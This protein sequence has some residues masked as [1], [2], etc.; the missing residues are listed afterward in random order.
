MSKRGIAHSQ[1][2]LEHLR[3][4]AQFCA[5]L[6]SSAQF[7][8]AVLCSAQF[9]LLETAD[10]CS[11]MDVVFQGVQT[12]RNTTLQLQHQNFIVT[13]NLWEY[14]DAKILT[15]YPTSTFES[16]FPPRLSLAESLFRNRFCLRS[17][18]RPAAS[19]PSLAG[20]RASRA[21]RGVAIDGRG[22][23]A[24]LGSSMSLR[25]ASLWLTAVCRLLWQ[26]SLMA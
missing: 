11:N 12:P 26:A 22:G 6:R 18:L 2:R 7:C 1:R 9:K 13:S 4:S 19:R 17:L 25:S 3:S 14:I 20:P 8:E 10:A 5:V 21:A 16:N 15:S 23:E 24:S